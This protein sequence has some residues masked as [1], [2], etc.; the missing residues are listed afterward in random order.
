VPVLAL[1]GGLVLAGCGGQARPGAAA[2]VGEK[3]IS[4]DEL[5]GVVTSALSNEAFAQEVAD[6]RQAFQASVLSRLVRRE[7]LAEAARRLDVSVSQA[8][9]DVTRALIEA[10]SDPATGGINAAAGRAGIP[11]SELDATLRD[12][13]LEAK[14]GEKL[15]GE[16]AE[17]P[18]EQVRQA[19]EQTGLANEGY[20]FET[21]QAQL[22]RELLRQQSSQA[23][24][25]YLSELASKVKVTVNPR[26]GRFSAQ[27]VAVAPPAGANDDGSAGGGAQGGAPQDSPPEGTAPDGTTPEGTA[28]DGT[29]PEGTAPEGTAPEAPA[30]ESSE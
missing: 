26:F 25:Q 11:A 23:V 17:V 16:Q 28:P 5:Q 7:L 20:T 27:Q 19:F 1:V 13:T 3:R 24:G 14:V 22:R 8:D 10:Q 4:S 12:L 9:I 6:R 18:T 21:A 15:L 2:F 29:T 30:P